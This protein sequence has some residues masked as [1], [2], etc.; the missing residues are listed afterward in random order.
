MRAKSRCRRCSGSRTEIL[1]CI[2]RETP[3]P[4]YV[5]VTPRKPTVA[6]KERVER[7]AGDGTDLARQCADLWR[8]LRD[9]GPG[10]TE[11]VEESQMTDFDTVMS[12]LIQYLPH[13]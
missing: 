7:I 2:P 5:A 9:L 10:D 11:E 3:S 8:Q 6:E 12:M 13:S 1:H 4:N